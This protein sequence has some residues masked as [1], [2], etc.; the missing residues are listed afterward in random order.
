[1]SAN[2][3]GRT[4]R[5]LCLGNDRE[6]WADYNSAA[7]ARGALGRVRKRPVAIPDPCRPQPECCLKVP[8]RPA[9]ASSPPRGLRGSGTGALRARG[10][11]PLCEPP[12]RCT[13]SGQGSVGLG[14]GRHV[15]AEAVFV[16]VFTEFPQE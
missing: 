15:G 16:H 3:A 10:S 12:P 14:N 1:M 2:V 9:T 5:I 8:R 13:P 4:S 11:P 7:G 6:P